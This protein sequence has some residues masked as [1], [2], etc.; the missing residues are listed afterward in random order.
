VNRVVYLVTTLLTAASVAPEFSA[1]CLVYA[2]HRHPEWRDRI[3]QEIAALEPQ[4]LYSVPIEKLPLTL[5][6]IKEAAR[7]W[8]FPFIV[9]RL[10]AR[11]IK[12]DGVEVRKGGRYEVSLYVLHHLDDYWQEPERFDPD[13]WL[14]PRKTA[15]K[16]TYMPFGFAPRSCV[17]GAV[18]HAVLFLVCELFTRSFKVDMASEAT[19]RLT[20]N[21]I[22]VPVDMI[23][24][25]RRAAPS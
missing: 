4:E 13:R 20:M 22:A 5:R 10:A 2:M 12:V 16:G 24:S 7:M 14:S 17:G 6:F 18:G 15:T 19:P 25:I 21:G 23:G 11:D 9:R 3:E 1:C 8:P